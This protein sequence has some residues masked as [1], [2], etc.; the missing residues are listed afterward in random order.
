MRDVPSSYQPLT[1]VPRIKRPQQRQAANYITAQTTPI[2]LSIAHQRRSS[3]NLLSIAKP[4]TF[5]ISWEIHKNEMGYLAFFFFSSLK[6]KAFM[7]GLKASS[8][9]CSL[10]QRNTVTMPLT[11]HCFISNRCPVLQFHDQLCVTN[12]ISVQIGGLLINFH[13]KCV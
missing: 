8:L 13:T 1:A 3:N 5:N 6:K 10:P 9:Y 7:R 4:L 12:A 2:T 11:T